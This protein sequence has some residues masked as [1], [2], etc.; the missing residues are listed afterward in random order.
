VT[1]I[2]YL[3]GGFSTTKVAITGFGAVATPTLAVRQGLPL[4]SYAAAI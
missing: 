2:V 3:K 4:I 1:L